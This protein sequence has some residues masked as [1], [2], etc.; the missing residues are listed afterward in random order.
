[1]RPYIDVG[2]APTHEDCAQVGSPDYAARSVKECQTYIRQLRRLFG[3]EPDGAHLSVR[4]NP[5]D[6]GTY[7]SAVCYY[8]ESLPASVDYA[9]RCE[10]EMPQ[11]WDAISRQEL[12]KEETQ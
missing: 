8:N 11:Q 12:Q 10:G 5:H 2:S 1:M 3:D 6:F 7:Y 4:A 9:F